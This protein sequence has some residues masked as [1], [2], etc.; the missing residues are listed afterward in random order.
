MNFGGIV[1]RL[2]KIFYPAAPKQKPTKASWEN[3]HDLRSFCSI[4]WDCHISPF[5]NL[6]KCRLAHRQPPMSRASNAP[7]IGLTQPHH[8]LLRLLGSNFCARNY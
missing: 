4:F 7:R 1:C 2:L 6:A 5:S 8:L 3:R